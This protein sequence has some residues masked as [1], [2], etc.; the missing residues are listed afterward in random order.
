MMGNAAVAA[1]AVG[2]SAGVVALIGDDVRG[3]LILDGLHDR[4]V[5]TAFVRKIAAP[6][7]W[8]LSLTTP[9]GERSLIQFWT[10]AFGADFDVFDRAALSQ[11]RWVHTTAEQGEPVLGLLR[12]AAAA[13]ARVSLDVEAPFVERDDL[14]ELVAQSDVVF[15]NEGAAAWLGGPA[16]AAAFIHRCSEADAV[17]T[18]GERGAELHRPNAPVHVLPAIEV[19]AVDTNGAGDAMAGAFAAGMLRGL[20]PDEAGELGVLVAGLSTTAMGGFGP[21]LDPQEIVEV[22]RRHGYAWAERL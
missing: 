1:A 19:H 11:V 15:L 9:I 14:P 13:G 6:T 20:Q 12:E 7:F 17:I 22:A 10:D 18:L 4:G 16:E 2:A 8:T 5:D 3:N 21:A